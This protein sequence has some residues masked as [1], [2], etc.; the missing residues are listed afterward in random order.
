MQPQYRQGDVFLRQVE[1]LPLEAREASGTARI[2]LAYGEATGHSHSV[3]VQ[4][5]KLYNLQDQHFLVVATTAKLVHEEHETIPLPAGVYK[6][7]R[8]REYAPDGSLQYVSD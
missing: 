7:V 1:Q 6:V 2:V 5:A 4:E 3:S 8:Q